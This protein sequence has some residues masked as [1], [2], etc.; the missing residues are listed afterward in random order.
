MYQK[1]TLA[2]SLWKSSICYCCASV[3]M[4]LWH[5]TYTL[6]LIA[7]LCFLINRKRLSMLRFQMLGLIKHQ[8]HSHKAL[9]KSWPGA[10]PSEIWSE[11]FNT[12]PGGQTEISQ[13]WLKWL[14][15][16]YFTWNTGSSATFLETLLCEARKCSTME[17][18][19]VT[20]ED[21]WKIFSILQCWL[22]TGGTN[23]KVVMKLSLLFLLDYFSVFQY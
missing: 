20:H 11:G 19:S 15:T 1:E 22:T 6:R 5:L 17:R 4:C 23:C 14:L 2:N 13:R 21:C 8:W 3:Q 9:I 16:N 18:A 10:P 7:Q 12:Q